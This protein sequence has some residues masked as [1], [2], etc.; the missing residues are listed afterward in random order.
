MENAIHWR[1]SLETC[2]LTLALRLYKDRHGVW[3]ERLE[4][5]VPE[6][7]P[8]VPIEPCSG[9]PLDYR[10]PGGGWR[11]R[12]GPYHDYYAG[13][14]EILAQRMTTHYD[15]RLSGF[16][17]A[18]GERLRAPL[19]SSEE[20][21]EAPVQWEQRLRAEQAEAKRLAEQAAGGPTLP[22]MMDVRIL[23]RY[24]LIPKR[25]KFKVWTNAAGADA[26]S[27]RTTNA[28]AA[29]NRSAGL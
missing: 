3:P 8:A 26:V 24:G 16:R 27:A 25:Y 28:P 5:L 2:R 21:K 20:A 22:R 11:V 10:R 13:R 19:C 1:C 23:Q 15:L 12:P 18:P 14:D 17:P 9:L 29:A 4:E 6:F 7:L